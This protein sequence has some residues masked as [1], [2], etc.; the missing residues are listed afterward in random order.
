[1][2]AGSRGS[3]NGLDTG[4]GPQRALGCHD[5]DE[6]GDGI[7]V[8]AAG[9]GRRRHEHRRPLPRWRHS[10]WHWSG[11]PHHEP[12]RILPIATRSASIMARFDGEEVSK[13]RTVSLELRT[14][15]VA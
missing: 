14:K 9:S 4:D 6:G 15:A 5:K 11:S 3:T 12:D 10:P 7:R 1:V 8:T 13:A 2:E